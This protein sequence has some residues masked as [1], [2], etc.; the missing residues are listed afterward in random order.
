MCEGIPV[1]M[2]LQVIS[3]MLGCIAIVIPIVVT[4]AGIYFSRQFSN[5]IESVAADLDEALD[6]IKDLEK[7]RGAT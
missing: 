6:R 3:V 2:Y 7:A 1:A 5:R 4:I